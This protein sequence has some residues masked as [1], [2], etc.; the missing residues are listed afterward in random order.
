MVGPGGDER[1]TQH[2]NCV[3]FDSVEKAAG[4]DRT[5]ALAS[6][7]PAAR[8]S[9]ARR[10]LF[11]D[12]TATSS[13]AGRGSVVVKYLWRKSPTAMEGRVLPRTNQA[14]EMKMNCKTA[15]PH[16]SMSGSIRAASTM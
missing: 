16:Q 6:S 7:P 1:I 10:S 4:Y 3:F 2:S 11:R 14:S 15:Y 13:S 8:S 12:S 5:G 9:S